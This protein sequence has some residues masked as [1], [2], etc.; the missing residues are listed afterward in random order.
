MSRIEE[1]PAEEEEEDEAVALL[2]LL[3]LLLLRFKRSTPG[4]DA[5]A[6]LFAPASS[7]SREG[8][9]VPEVEES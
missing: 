8:E 2:L 7:R 6:L 5:A 9:A 3:L 4:F 1:A